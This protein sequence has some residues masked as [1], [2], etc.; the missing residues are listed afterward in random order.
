MC[1]LFISFL[2]VFLVLFCTGDSMITVKHS[3]RPLINKVVPFI[4]FAP[5]YSPTFYPLLHIWIHP[6]CSPY[7]LLLF[8]TIHP[9]PL[10]S[11]VFA[12]SSFVYTVHAPTLQVK[13]SNPSIPPSLPSMPHLVDRWRC[14]SPPPS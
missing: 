9:L 6:T 5:S 1:L 12:S 11:P 7:Y 10:K 14:R 8:L 3:L 2:N 4:F 13:K